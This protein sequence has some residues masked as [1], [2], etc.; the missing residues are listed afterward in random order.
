M[1]SEGGEWGGGGCQSDE[2]GVELNEATWGLS[3]MRVSE[4][5]TLAEMVRTRAASVRVSGGS[6][7][8]LSPTY[9]Y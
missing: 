5:V 7:S 8:M 9:Q 3:G 2:L 6:H 4:A 1:A